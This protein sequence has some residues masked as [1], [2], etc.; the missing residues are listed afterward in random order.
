MYTRYRRASQIAVLVLMFLIPILNRYEIYAITGTFYAVNIGGLGIADPATILQAIFASARLT[1]PLLSAALFPVIL[2]FLFGRVWCGWMCPYHVVSDAAVWLRNRFRANVLKRTEPERLPCAGSVRGNTVRFGFLMLG[3][4]AAGAI[5]IPVLN[6]VNAPGVLS[7]EAMILVKERAVSLEVG[8]IV[9]LFVLEL[10]LLPRFWC[11]LFCPTGAVVSVFRL[12][13]TVRV[14][15]ELKAPRVPCCTENHC[16]ASCPMGLSPYREGH[17]LL[18]TNCGRCI[19][20]CP[21][22]RLR[23]D[24]F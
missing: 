12:P 2:A 13:F 16:S 22:Q 18:C 6:Y 20:A 5:G 8:F 19:D 23:F 24:G 1:V 3:S 17:N 9:G 10:C 11:R 21:K 15:N 7:T 14:A 4:F